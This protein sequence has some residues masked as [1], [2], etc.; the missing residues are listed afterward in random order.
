MVVITRSKYGSYPSIE[1]FM[2]SISLWS[3]TRR[4][5]AIGEFL[6]DTY[7]IYNHRDYIHPDPLEFLYYYKDPKDIEIVALLCSSLAYGRVS[8]ILKSIDKVLFPM[9]KQDISPRDFIETNSNA[10]FRKIYSSFKHRF[11]TSEDLVAMLIS[12]K[13]MI[14]KYGSLKEGFLSHYDDSNYLGGVSSFCREFGIIK[15]FFPDP[16]QSV[17]KRLHLFLRWMIRSDEVDL[18]IWKEVSTKNLYV[19]VDTHMLR[20]YSILS[21]DTKSNSGLQVAKKIRDF[22]ATWSPKD[23]AKYDFSLTRFG[24]RKNNESLI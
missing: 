9:K 17:C 10:D 4:N 20:I 2:D 19:P 22:F 14:K 1:S 16:L 7:Q 12:I 24:I 13:K 5:R 15:S 11:T 6:E 23:P 21:K 18:G 8:Q 3:K